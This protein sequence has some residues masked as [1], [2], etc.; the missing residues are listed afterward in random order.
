MPRKKVLKKAPKKT[1][2]SLMFSTEYIEKPR[3]EQIDKALAFCKSKAEVLR[4]LTK[5][6]GIVLIQ[7]YKVTISNLGSSITKA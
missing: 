4:C 1:G 5:T 2:F 3:L 7:P 6:H